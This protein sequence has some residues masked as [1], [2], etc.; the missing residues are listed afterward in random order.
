M[1]R[2]ALLDY[3]IQIVEETRTQKAVL[4]GVSPRGTLAFLKA[5]QAYALIEGREY[6]IPEDI[7]R[8]AVPVL[9]HRI[10]LQGGMIS[11]GG[12]AAVEQILS[13]VSVPTEEWK[14]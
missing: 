7:R 3:M 8:L 12:K 11:G 13:M 10:V 9:A 5:I 2:T 1:P 14:R 4:L 6:V